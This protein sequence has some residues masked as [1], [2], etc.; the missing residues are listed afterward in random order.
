MKLESI[1]KEIK[2]VKEVI[3]MY[4]HI[5]DKEEVHNYDLI[6][7]RLRKQKI[8]LKKGIKFAY[9]PN[10]ASSYILLK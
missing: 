5:G 10:K 1:N 8:A 2:V 7:A 3:S 9:Q 4:R 6:L